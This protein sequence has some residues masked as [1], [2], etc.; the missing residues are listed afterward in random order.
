M[1]H[2]GRSVRRAREYFTANEFGFGALHVGAIALTHPER[3]V[4]WEYLH[5][6]CAGDELAPGADGDFSESPI[7]Y[8]NDG[9]L[10]FDACGVSS[11]GGNS[12][13]VSGFLPL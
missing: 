7:F 8:F 11:A 12:G 1:R 9:K 6:D 5:T 10:R 13:S 4:R 3:Y 2:R